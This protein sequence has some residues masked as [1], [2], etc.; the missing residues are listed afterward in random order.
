MYWIRLRRLSQTITFRMA[1]SFAMA[2]ACILL[3][4]SYGLYSLA[5][6]QLTK[7]DRDV[8]AD[9]VSLLTITLREQDNNQFLLNRRL[10]EE[11]SAFHFNRYQVRLLS[12]TK[13]QRVLF[14][15]VHFPANLIPRLAQVPVGKEE[16]WRLPKGRTF[17]ILQVQGLL[18]E[19]N[20]E[21]ILVQT[22]LET[23]DRVNTLARLKNSL[24]Q[25]IFVGVLL[26]SLLG[27]VVV[28]LGLRPLRQFSLRI[29]GIRMDSLDARMNAHDWPKELGPLAEAFNRLLARLEKD[30]DQLTRFSG[31]LAHE[32]RTPITNLRVETEVFLAKE[33]SV[34]EYRAVLENNLIELER[35]SKVIERILLLAKVDSPQL[36]LEMAPFSMAPLVHKLFDFYAL[37]AE[38]KE[39]KLSLEGDFIL[40]ADEPLVEQALGNLLSNALKYTPAK[41]N[42]T[43]RLIQERAHSGQG[44]VGVISVGDDGLGISPEHLPHIFER[45]YRADSSRSQVIAGDG[46][47][48]AIVKAIM[49]VHDGEVT[50]NSQAG[51]GSDFRLRF[52]LPAS[53]SL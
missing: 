13:P 47:G 34:D 46:L 2:S 53:D 22:V 41:G 32:L 1:I 24:I 48:L 18:G 33:R 44:E 14:Q 15:S 8:L 50:V 52:G 29:Q 39:I 17:L 30:V 7:D 31:D 40:C 35:L 21:P 16:S 51:R 27:I 36:A 25:L 38:E 49:D 4:L 45:F 11:L 23:T 19:H 3:V 12:N 43:V 9:A 42:V 28:S 37:L 10:P 20:P 5:N 26:F 6:S